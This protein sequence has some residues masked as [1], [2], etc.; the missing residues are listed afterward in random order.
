MR[1]QINNKFNGVRNKW[2][3]VPVDSKE[4][5]LIIQDLTSAIKLGS[6][7]SHDAIDLVK[8]FKEKKNAWIKFKTVKGRTKQF[9]A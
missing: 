7:K 5:K 1:D 8:I 2:I 6:I 4:F 9:C 3:Y